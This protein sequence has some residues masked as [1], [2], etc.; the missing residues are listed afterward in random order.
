MD[1]K[2][3]LEKLSATVQLLN[4]AAADYSSDVKAFF[5]FADAIIAINS[6]HCKC[7]CHAD[8]DVN[9]LSASSPQNSEWKAN[10]RTNQVVAAL[11]LLA[12]VNQM[13]E[14]TQLFDN[15]AAVPC[16]TLQQHH[17]AVELVAS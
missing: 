6:N 15:P 1:Q 8:E 3:L 5:T 17:N 16:D 4:Y 14:S 12:Q 9:M 7:C 11:A 2:S 13:L 10:P